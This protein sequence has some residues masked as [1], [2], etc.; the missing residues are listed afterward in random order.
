MF[1]TELRSLCDSVLGNGNSVYKN[2]VD[3]CRS[4]NLF[5]QMSKVNSWHRY[6]HI[7]FCDAKVDHI[8]TGEVEE[9]M[10][11]KIYASVESA[12]DYSISFAF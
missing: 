11:H 8:P 6:S 9:V 3:E 5:S 4:E 1:S 10:G 7:C 2:A 12:N